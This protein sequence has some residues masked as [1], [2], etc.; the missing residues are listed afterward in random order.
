MPPNAPFMVWISRSFGA[1][2]DGATMPARI[3]DCCAPGRSIRY[4]RGFAGAATVADV[5]LRHL[6]A[7]AFQSPNAASSCGMICVQR[8]VAGDQDL[9]V[10]RTHEI[11]A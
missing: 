8:G 9:H 7:G 4:T 1:F 10:V 3:S 11:A 6:L 2:V 5:L